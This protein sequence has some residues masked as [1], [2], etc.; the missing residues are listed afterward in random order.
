MT[1]SY[2]AKTTKPHD[3]YYSIGYDAY[4]NNIPRDLAND[5]VLADRASYLKGWDTAKSDFLNKCPVG[6]RMKFQG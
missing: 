4:V 5:L 1:P 2:K 3:K 6:P